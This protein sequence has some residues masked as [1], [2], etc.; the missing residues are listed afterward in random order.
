MTSNAKACVISTRRTERLFNLTGKTAVVTGASRGIGRAIAELLAE[1]GAHVIAV[2]RGEADLAELEALGIDCWT[3]DV[4]SPKFHERLAA[5]DV[6]ILVNNAGTNRPMPMGDV[7]V[8]VL[9]LL[10]NLNVRASFLTAQAAVRSMQR[11][12][13]PGSVVNMTSQMGHVGSPGR[14]V[15]C[16]TKHALEGLTKAMAVELAPAGIRVNSVAPTFVETPMTLPMLQDPAFKSLVLGS[17][18]MGRMATTD[19]VAAAVLYLVSPA[20]AMVTGTSLLVDGGWTA[21]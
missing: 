10:L 1:A 12:G 13:V 21:Q 5:S 19:E 16:M 2:A 15:Y 8:D 17:I 14:T 4:T 6:D 11:R 7:P 20:A 9:D 3:E 18:P